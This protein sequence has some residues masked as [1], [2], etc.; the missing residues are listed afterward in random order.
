LFSAS[1]DG[2]G[3]F[4]D[5]FELANGIMSDPSFPLKASGGTAH[6]AWVDVAVANM[7]IFVNSATFVQTAKPIAS[8][9]GPYL[10][11]ATSTAVPATISLDGSK[12]FDPNGRLLAARW[13]FGDGTPPLVVSDIA[14][15][16]PHAY[17]APGKYTVTLVLNNGTAD[18]EPATTTVDVF[19]A[20]PPDAVG[21]TPF[22]AA[23][24]AEVRVSGVA[25]PVA[26]VQR[27]WNLSQGPLVFDPVT[28]GIAGTAQ[29]A[30]LALPGLSFETA[31]ALP[32]GLPPGSYRAAV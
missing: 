4:G 9:S 20:L 19:P 29:T 15:P 27:G 32:A 30:P 13:D 5:A 1:I 2:G 24:G 16:V 25:A 21:V 28:V 18:S 12:S 22:C 26:L 31:F 23:P 11:W 14:N 3:T 7:D 6:V 10:G 17:A 8:A